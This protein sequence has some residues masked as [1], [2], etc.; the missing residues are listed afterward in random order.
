MSNPNVLKAVHRILNGQAARAFNVLRVA[1]AVKEG[2]NVV[3]DGL[4]FQ[5]Q[6]NASFSVTAGA[7]VVDLTAAASTAG[8]TGTLTSDNTAPSDGDTVTIGS[9]TYTFKTALTP[10]EGEVLINST[11]DAALLNLIRAINHSGT[12]GTDYQCAAANTRVTAATSVTS[13][14]FAITSKGKGTVEALTVATTETSAHLSFGA[15]TLTGGTDASAS[16]YTTALNTAMNATSGP[17]WGY[18]SERI[19]A[20]QIL[21]STLRSSGAAAAA[22][23][24]LSGSN[25]AWASATFYGGLGESQTGKKVSLSQRVPNATEIALT[26]MS[27]LL[28]FTPTAV[29]IQQTDS[30]GTIKAFDGTVVISGNRV[31]ATWS[32]SVSIATNDLVNVLASE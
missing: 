4:T 8:G 24:T 29:I 2:E 21:V 10:T 20:N 23:E 1:S 14:A 15:A 7:V 16:D 3:V 9:K 30:S 12:P 17:T 19:S 22:T 6:L 13:H 5:A 18:K 26:S 28:T 11:A 32:G 27:W 25:N 31:T